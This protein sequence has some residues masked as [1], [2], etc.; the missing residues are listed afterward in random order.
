MILLKGRLLG[1]HMVG[2][3]PESLGIRSF[4]SRGK[5]ELILLF[6]LAILNCDHRGSVYDRA[7]ARFVFARVRTTLQKNPATMD[8][9]SAV[10]RV[11]PLTLAP[12]QQNACQRRQLLQSL[13]LP[14][15]QAVA[16]LDPLN[17]RNGFELICASLD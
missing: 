5:A 16:S 14:Q 17:L 12:F 7:S 10:T 3:Q 9:A 8:R 1:P 15:V 13:D 6:I 11:R 2:H 4:I